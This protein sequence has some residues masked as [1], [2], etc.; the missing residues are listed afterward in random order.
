[1]RLHSVHAIIIFDEMQN[2]AQDIHSIY[3]CVKAVNYWLVFSAKMRLSWLCYDDKTDRHDITQILLKWPQIAPFCISSK[4]I[5][6]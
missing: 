3:Q 4:I 6:A 5:M 1:M 2:G